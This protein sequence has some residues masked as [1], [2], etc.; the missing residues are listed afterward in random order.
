MKLTKFEEE[1]VASLLWQIR[2]CKEHYVTERATNRV[3]RASI[4]RI[5][6]RPAG[7][8]IESM[9]SIETDNDHAVPVKVIIQYL[10]DEPSLTKDRVIEILD[11]FYVSVTISKQE[12]VSVLRTLG[13][14]S[15]MPDGWDVVDPFARYKHAGI[16]LLLNTNNLPG[17]TVL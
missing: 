17:P 5:K 7:C 9:N 6:L 16:E 3:L 14:E 12:H 13:L 8:S 15:K 2:G 4:R 11:R 1:I 10:M